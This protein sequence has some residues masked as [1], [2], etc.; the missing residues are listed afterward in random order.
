[1]KFIVDAQLL[2]RLA[3]EIAALGGE[4]V[5]T[6][7]LPSANRTTDAEIMALAAREQRTVVTKDS[8]FVDFLFLRDEPE[9]LLLIA[10]GNNPND[11]LCQLLRDNWSQILALLEQGRF[12]ELSR[13]AILL[14]F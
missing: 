9:K 7:D 6:L 8:D 2:R 12:V 4:A 10:T 13:T 3:R 11:E 1:M 14:H 5:H